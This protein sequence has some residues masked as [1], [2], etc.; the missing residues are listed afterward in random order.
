[1]A[2]L[3]SLFVSRGADGKWDEIRISVGCWSIVLYKA[4]YGPIGY[5]VGELYEGH[6][7][8]SHKV[9][10]NPVVS[11]NGRVFYYTEIHNSNT[12][13]SWLRSR[14]V[15]NKNLNFSKENET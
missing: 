4:E 11:F 2:K 8:V 13:E 5:K 7:G 3:D 15:L 12:D 14:P 6:W 9:G 1:M 10:T